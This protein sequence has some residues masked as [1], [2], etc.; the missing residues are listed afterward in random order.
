MTPLERLTELFQRFPG[1]GPRQAQ[2][3]VFHLLKENPEYI[4]SLS[5][6]IRDVRSSV[7]EC[8]RC[9]R[10]FAKKNGESTCAICADPTRDA[11]L[12]M[13]VE[14]DAD[15][16]PIERGKS[17]NGLYFVLGGT[18]PLLDQEHA[19]RTRGPALKA[20]VEKR[21]GEGLEE[22]ILAFSVN[23]DG[24]NTARYVEAQLASWT[25]SGKLTVS[26]LGRGLSTGSEL[27]Y[28]DSETIK[29]ALKNRTQ[30]SV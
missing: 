5:S 6:L 26:T 1:I 23:P 28:V 14:R 13:I 29:N 16:A 10:F 21:L 15:I 17:Y 9:F 8:D 25:E 27:E 2:R 30:G 12:M 24:E 4:D 7:R 20:I 3:F 18:I 22:V 11:S 19:A